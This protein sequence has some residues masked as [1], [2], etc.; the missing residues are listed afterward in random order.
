MKK[1]VSY[2]KQKLNNKIF[3]T[4]LGC[5]L[6]FHLIFTLREHLPS[7]AYRKIFF[8]IINDADIKAIITQLQI[9]LS[10]AI[11]LYDDKRGYY[12]AV[13]LNLI[14]LWGAIIFVFYSKGPTSVPAIFTYVAAIII[15][16]LIYSYKTSMKKH[17][18]QLKKKENEL[19]NLAYFD[20]LTAVLNR[21]T[22]IDELDMHIEFFKISGKKLFVIF[23]DIDDF[24]NINDTLGHFAGDT[25][26]IEITRR[27]KQVVHEEDII[28]RLGGDELGIII[29][30]P[31]DEESVKDYVQKIS[32]A[33]MKPYSKDGM[34]I[35]PTASI[36]VAEYPKNGAYSAELLKNADIAMYHSKREGKNQI[37]YFE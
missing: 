14:S 16:S 17:L 25:V 24:K 19:K 31:I 2:L 21:K 8:V 30:H 10:V 29:K 27:L 6:Y 23:M 12:I 37:S 28:G 32:D 34:D 9:L 11:V 3:I 5:L 7:V 33:V 36:G 1:V 18:D 20:G 15:V 35:W 13:G 26:L 22:F 4:I